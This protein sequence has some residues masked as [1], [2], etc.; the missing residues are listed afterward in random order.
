MWT[1]KAEEILPGLHVE[2]KSEEQTE[3]KVGDQVKVLNTV[4]G[5]RE[6]ADGTPIAE[7]MVGTITHI[8]FDHTALV[9]F[10]GDETSWNFHIKEIRTPLGK[11]LPVD[12]ELVSNSQSEIA[13]KPNETESSEL[14]QQESTQMEPIKLIQMAM[15]ALTK[16]DV[17]ASTGYIDIPAQLRAQY[18]LGQATEKLWKKS[19]AEIKK[20]F[21]KEMHKQVDRLGRWGTAKPSEA[22][23]KDVIRK[24]LIKNGIPDYPEIVGALYANPFGKSGYQ[25]RGSSPDVVGDMGT[26]EPR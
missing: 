20:K 25:T 10:P 23:I 21:G 24:I 13:N 6:L 1:V 8:P 4:S 12:V 26:P 19:V 7:G 9:Q 17:S 15:D 2:D 16:N 22:N 3:F 18:L 14:T 11:K 5:N